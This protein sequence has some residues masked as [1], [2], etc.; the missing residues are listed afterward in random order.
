MGIVQP[1]IRVIQIKGLMER[2]PVQM[3]HDGRTQRP[4]KHAA[5][6]KIP[7]QMQRMARRPQP[8]MDPPMPVRIPARLA[9]TRVGVQKMRILHEIRVLENNDAVLGINGSTLCLPGF[10]AARI[11]SQH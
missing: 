10:P 5:L 4:P 2:V 9:T 11:V 7:V 8:H 3:L 1:A 6:D